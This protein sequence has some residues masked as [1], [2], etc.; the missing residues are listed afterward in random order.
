MSRKRVAERL[1]N[2]SE[3]AD[4]LGALGT[5]FE[6]TI[7]QKIPKTRPPFWSASKILV[8]STLLSIAALYGS[9]VYWP[10]LWFEVIGIFLKHDEPLNALE[11]TICP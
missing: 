7:V 10:H 3:V 9:W 1:T 11:W 4:R 5:S 2:L 8:V 6:H